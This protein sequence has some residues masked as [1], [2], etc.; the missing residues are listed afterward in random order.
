MS[1][2]LGCSQ[3][4]CGIGLMLALGLFTPLLAQSLRDPTVPPAAVTPAAAGDAHGVVTVQSGAVA[5]LVRNGTPYLVVGTRLYAKGQ[6]VG[7]A[8]IER[9]TETEVWLREEGSLRKVPV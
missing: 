6:K 5:V 2:A 3:V 7:L 8:S 9:I 1:A 4:G